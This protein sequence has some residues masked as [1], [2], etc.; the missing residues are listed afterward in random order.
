M[1]IAKLHGLVVEKREIAIRD[2]DRMTDAELQEHGEELDAQIA[3]GR[4][5]LQELDAAETVH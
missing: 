2:I 3:L 1:D 5:R 4:K